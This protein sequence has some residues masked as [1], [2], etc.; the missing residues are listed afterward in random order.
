MRKARIPCFRHLVVGNSNRLDSLRCVIETWEFYLDPLRLV[1]PMGK[2]KCVVDDLKR[3]I[4]LWVFLSEEVLVRFKAR[5]TDFCVSL[6][7]LCEVHA[8]SSGERLDYFLQ[9][10][11]AG[12]FESW[13]V[14]LEFGKH[15]FEV[16]VAQTVTLLLIVQDVPEDRKS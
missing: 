2:S 16:I 10:L 1:L 15:L 7:F 4:P 13:T 11:R 3:N 6:P 14:F 5:R 12:F 8:P 9:S